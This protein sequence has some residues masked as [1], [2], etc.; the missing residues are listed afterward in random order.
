MRAVFTQ[1]CT[2]LAPLL[3]GPAA[4]ISGFDMAH[5][6]HNRYPELTDAEIHV[7][8]SAATNYQQDR[9]RAGSSR[10]HS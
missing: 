6:L 9:P 2:L 5:M 10:R 3:A 8:I 7:L 4:T 1:A